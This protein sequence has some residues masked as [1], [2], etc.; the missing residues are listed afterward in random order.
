MKAGTEIKLRR[1]AETHR[2]D[3]EPVD[4]DDCSMLDLKVGDI[5]DVLREIDEIEKSRETHPFDEN[6][7]DKLISAHIRWPPTLTMMRELRDAIFD[8]MQKCNDAER[9][10]DYHQRR[11]QDYRCVAAEYLAKFKALGGKS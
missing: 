4:G 10:N 8:V 3:D 2:N 1:L 11:M 6:A 7:A 5:R 9:R